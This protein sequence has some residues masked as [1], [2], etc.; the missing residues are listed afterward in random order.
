LNYLEL[1]KIIIDS[2]EIVKEKKLPPRNQDKMIRFECR[3]QIDE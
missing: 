3:M 1:L 2:K